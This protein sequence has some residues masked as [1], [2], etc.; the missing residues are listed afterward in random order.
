MV[1]NAKNYHIPVM[2]NE[3]VHEAQAFSKPKVLDATYGGGGH[4]KELQ[5]FAGKL[6][7]L[8]LDPKAENHLLAGVELKRINFAKVDS[9]AGEFDIILADLGLSQN[10][11]ADTAKGFS[12]SSRIEQPLDMRLDDSLAITA[13][14]LLKVLPH[15]QLVK[16]FSQ[17]GHV[18]NSALLAREIIAK[19]KT[20]PLTTNLELNELVRNSLGNTELA[21]VYQALRVAV[22]LELENLRLFIDGALTK[23]TKRGMLLIITFHK[24]EEDVISLHPKIESRVVKPSGKEI[25]ENPRSRSAKLFVITRKDS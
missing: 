12:Y 21:R 2:L 1:S 22:N 8:D 24:G 15:K 18:R 19:R 5:K 4:S 17:Y 13:A 9:L 11:L 20:Q 6:V 25:Q 14:E 16:M 23:L 3:V 10:Q 7:V